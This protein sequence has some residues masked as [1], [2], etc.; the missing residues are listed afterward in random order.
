MGRKVDYDPEELKE[1][2]IEAAKDVATKK[3]PHE[4]NIRDIATIVGCSI[5]TIY[6]SF[7]NIYDIILHINGETLDL[8]KATLE[9]EVKKKNY[10]VNCGKT[11]GKIYIAFT[12]KH[13]PLWNLLFEHQH[14]LDEPLPRWYQNKIDETFSILEKSVAPEFSGDKK[15]LRRM[16]RALWAGLHGICVLEVS[17]KLKTTKSESPE[18]LWDALYKMYAHSI[19]QMMETKEV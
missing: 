18:R 15:K 17:G 19:L 11:V 13:L 9:R 10:K 7:K 3:G 5:G 12:K 16:T 2:I 6:N 14:P 1:K 4:L 8:L